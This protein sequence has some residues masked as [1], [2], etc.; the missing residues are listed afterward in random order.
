MYRNFK[1]PLALILTCFS[2]AVICC[3][4][5]SFAYTPKSGNVSATLGPFY[6]RTNFAGSESGARANTMGGVGL[7]AIGDIDTKGSLEIAMFQTNKLF[8]VDE[9]GTVLSE[10]LPIIQI[11]MGYRY[12][13]NN[14]LSTSLA[15]YSAY[16]M[17][18]PEV[19]HNDFP[20]GVIKDT[21]A[22]D[23]TEYGFDLSLTA[24]LFTSGKA[25]VILDTR[26]SLSVTPK[27]NEKS[28]HYGVLIGLRYL[29]QGNNRKSVPAV[30]PVPISN[31]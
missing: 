11:N 2:A 20:V 30:V 4:Q 19:I 18:D 15:F 8:F 24:D 23:T 9:N 21:S 25:S 17:G 26:Y 31:K 14:Y 1:N 28:D 12:W 29:V 7:I 6:Q 16:P 22:H 3:S 5:Q 10:K 13:I 27:E